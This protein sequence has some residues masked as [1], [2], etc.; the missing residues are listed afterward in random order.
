MKQPGYH[1]RPLNLQRQSKVSDEACEVQAPW[2]EP[3]M[4]AILP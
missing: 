3:S 2:L 1:T 4:L